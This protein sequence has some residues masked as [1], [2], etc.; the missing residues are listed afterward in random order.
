M[1]AATAADVDYKTL[2]DNF[3]RGFLTAALK[4]TRGNITRAAQNLQATARVIS[5][6]IR[7]LGIDLSQF[8]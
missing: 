5:Y 8:E 4:E 6:R 7:Q 1:G 2:V 3:E